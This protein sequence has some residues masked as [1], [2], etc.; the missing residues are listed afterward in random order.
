MLEAGQIR[1]NPGG[2]R[3]LLLYTVTDGGPRGD[4]WATLQLNGEHV[5][6]G[7]GVPADTLDEWH[8]IGTLPPDELRSE[9]VKR[10]A[11]RRF[12]PLKG[13]NQP[14]S[15]AAGLR[16]GKG[17]KRGKRRQTALSAS[18]RREA[19]ART[20]GRCA[21]PGCP[22]KAR[23]PHHLLPQQRNRWPE[24]ADVAANVIAVCRECHDAHEHGNLKGRMPKAVTGP[25]WALDLDARQ[26]AYLDATYG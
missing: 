13:Q 7:F 17:L 16:Q 10:T 1:Q 22:R 4:L 20:K 23:D 18:T 9:A 21:V 8:L 24:L 11:L 3:L 14:L 2:R 5:G 6:D 19:F 15:R 25:V 12:S 26:L